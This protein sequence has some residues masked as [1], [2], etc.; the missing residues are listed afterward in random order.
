M[1]EFEH[2][3]FI[4]L[5]LS[6]VL[7]AKPPRQRWA[8]LIILVGVLL[9]FLPPPSHI[10]IPWEIILGMVIPLLLW[11]NTR[12]LVNAD[13]RGWKSVTLWAITALIFSIAIGLIGVLNWPGALLFGII[14]SS[15]IWRAGEPEVGTSYMSQVGPLTLMFLLTEVEVAIQSPDHYLGGIFSGAFFG[16]MTA[17]FGLFLLRKLPPKFHAGVGIGQVAYWLSYIVGVS[18]VTAAVISVMVFIWLNQYYRLGFHEKAPPAPLNTWSGFIIVL[19]LFMLLGWQAHQ[20]ISSLLMI[21]V[22]VGTLVGLLITWVGRRWEIPAFH[23]ERT[24]WMT[25]ARMALLLFPA[26]LLWPRNSLHQPIQLAVAFAIAVLVIGFSHMG[27]SFYFPKGS[28]SKYIN[29]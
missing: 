25:G 22:A 28:H 8:T 10:P 17:L 11:Q 3:I 19:A 12:R 13:W 7:N 15:M 24:Y 9:V 14:A 26:L 18:A 16:V 21:E 4:L 23:K 5:L 2:T 1:I 6:G 27:L 29:R 20:P